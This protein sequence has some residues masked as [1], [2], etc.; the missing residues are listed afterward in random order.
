M[1]TLQDSRSPVQRLMAA[2][3]RINERRRLQEGQQPAQG[4][5][6]RPPTLF[7]RFHSW[8]YG[9]GNI[10]G[11]LT[12]AGFIGVFF[13]I[14]AMVSERR[15]LVAFAESFAAWV[16][17]FAVLLGPMFAAAWIGGKVA[18]RIS[19]MKLVFFVG[20][21]LWGCVTAVLFLAALKIP[22]IGWRIERFM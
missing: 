10:A 5:P 4:S 8:L 19:R 13:A 21:V 12:L 20:L 6:R 2:A 17:A 14:E 15:P 7:D 22:G 11:Y 1:N 16:I 3:K 9:F 18:A